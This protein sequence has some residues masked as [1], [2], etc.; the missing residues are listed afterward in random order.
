VNAIEKVGRL[1][2]ILS[3]A[4]AAAAGAQTEAETAIEPEAMAAMDRMS[5]ALRALPGFRFDADTT[6]EEVLET[7]QKL[8]FGGKLEVSARKPGGFR[9]AA[10]ADTVDREYIYDGRSLTIFAPRYNYYAVVPAPPSNGQII[11]K[12]RTE[13]GIELPLADPFIWNSDQT[14]RSRIKSAFALRPET[15]EGRSC[16]HYAFRQEKV[17]WQIWIEEGERALPCKM[18]VT[19]TSDPSLPQYVAVIHWRDTNDPPVSEFTFTPPAEAKR[20]RLASLMPEPSQG[21]PK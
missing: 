2:A 16:F 7:G 12:A 9:I 20:I 19:S 3:L 17:D 21:V 4:A 8:Q 13:L 15:I 14:M 11:D 18:I 10:H 5:A 1:C 6:M